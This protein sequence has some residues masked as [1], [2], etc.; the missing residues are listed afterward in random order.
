MNQTRSD[1]PLERFERQTA[2][3]M[4]ILALAIIPLLLI[5]TIFDLS[6][7]AETTIIALDWFIWAAFFI[8]YCI[9]LY[10]APKKRQFVASNKIDLVVIALPFLRPLRVVRS[11]RMLRV[12]RAAR[13]AT[14]LGRGIDAA[15]RRSHSP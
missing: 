3:P 9:R 15:K 7:G 11:A 6:A 1:E 13:A 10:L 5:P 4:L 2:V 14:F 12:L 8:E